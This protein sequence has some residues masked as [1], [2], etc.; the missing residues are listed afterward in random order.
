[1]CV[2]MLYIFP[3]TIGRSHSWFA[4]LYTK[5]LCYRVLVSDSHSVLCS[6]IWGCEEQGAYKNIKQQLEWLFGTRL[7]G[8]KNKIECD[9]ML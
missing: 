5:P 9:T 1:M 2:L 4:K 8:Q 3:A 6:V 7:S